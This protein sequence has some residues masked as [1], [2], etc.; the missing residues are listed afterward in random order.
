ME[1][2]Y[3]SNKKITLLFPSFQHFRDQRID[4]AVLPLVTEE[5]LTGMLQM[6][7]GP[8]LKLKMALASR[9]EPCSQC[10]ALNAA[11]A[12]AS[13]PGP[14]ING[15]AVKSEPRSNTTSPS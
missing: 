4:G 12:A 2:A 10:Q 6:K 15:S 9:L 13:A 1:I 11:A 8:A 14:R 7:L 5:Q 3:L